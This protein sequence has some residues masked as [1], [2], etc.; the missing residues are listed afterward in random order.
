MKGEESVLWIKVSGFDPTCQWM[1]MGHDAGGP[2]PPVLESSVSEFTLSWFGKNV[3]KIVTY[4]QHLFLLQIMGC[5][6]CDKNECKIIV[7]KWT[8][9]IEGERL[10]ELN[11]TPPSR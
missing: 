4:I 1:M 10:F 2:P 9:G 3:G 5:M 7:F 6:A 11:N 8:H